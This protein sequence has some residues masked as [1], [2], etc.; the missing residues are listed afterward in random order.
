MMRHL[1]TVSLAV[2]ASVRAKA[3]DPVVDLGYSSYQGYYNT[4]TGL[5]IWK[6]CAAITSVCHTPMS[7][8]RLH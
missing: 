1:L 3:S 4:T 5:N 7:H 2:V 8:F 6:G